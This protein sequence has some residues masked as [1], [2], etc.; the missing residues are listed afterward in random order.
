MT[1]YEKL[2]QIYT[3]LVVEDFT[4]DGTILIGLDDD[5]NEI[6]ERWDHP[7]LSEPTPE[8]LSKY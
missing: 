4:T 8:I 6:I 2:R 5:G 1:L 3:E 7:T